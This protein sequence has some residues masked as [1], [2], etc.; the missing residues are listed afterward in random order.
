MD[1]QSSAI[2]VLLN[3]ADSR[4]C[5]ILQVAGK[6]LLH[7]LLGCRHLPLPTVSDTT[8]TNRLGTSIPEVLHVANKIPAWAMSI[9]RSS[10]RQC[11]KMAQQ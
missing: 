5:S 11:P 9:F 10:N 1:C 4:Q 2:H 6:M 3:M 7:E 8:Y